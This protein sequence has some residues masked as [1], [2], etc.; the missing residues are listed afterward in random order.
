MQYKCWGHLLDQHDLFVHQ[1]SDG[2]CCCIFEQQK[3]ADSKHKLYKNIDNAVII[4][5]FTVN[6]NLSV[7]VCPIV[8]YIIIVQSCKI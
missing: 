6:V 8:A 1:S 7:S 4:L 2:T 3:F 5:L